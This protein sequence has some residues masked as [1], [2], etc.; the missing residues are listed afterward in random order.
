MEI[1]EMHTHTYSM[2]FHQYPNLILALLYVS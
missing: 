1:V 2:I